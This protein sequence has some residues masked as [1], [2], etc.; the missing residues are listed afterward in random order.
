MGDTEA[1]VD[2]TVGENIVA[3]DGTEVGVDVESSTEIGILLLDAEGRHKNH[4]HAFQGE[5]AS[6][7]H[8]NLTNQLH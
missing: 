1:G 4:Q 6:F 5:L 2:E 7:D 8:S 3:V